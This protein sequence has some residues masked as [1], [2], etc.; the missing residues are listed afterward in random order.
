MTSLLLYT[1]LTFLTWQTTLTL[2]SPTDQSFDVRSTN[3]GPC[4]GGGAAF[5]A[6]KRWLFD[7][8]A[9]GFFNKSDA[10][11]AGT[12]PNQLLYSARNIDS[13]GVHGGISFLY[14]LNGEET[15]LGLGIPLVWRKIS[16][17]QPNSGYRIADPRSFNWGGALDL[18][19]RRGK[20]LFKT[21]VGFLQSPSNFYFAFGA[22][23]AP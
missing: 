15:L 22:G 10:G 23:I 19:L 3:L 8:N 7:L 12:V 13:Y 17:P 21:A 14:A 9:C 20:F 4:L 1:T 2:L 18:R 5:P 6:G 16:W 11:I